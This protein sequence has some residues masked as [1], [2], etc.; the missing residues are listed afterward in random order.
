VYVYNVTYSACSAHACRAELSSVLC[1]DYLIFPH[2]VKTLLS[3]KVR[4]LI[5]LSESF[6]I[7]RRIE[8]DI[9][10]VQGFHGEYPFFLAVFNES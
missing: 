4:V 8:R 1:V 2:F 3:V 7:L 6:L 5:F 9:V 10:K